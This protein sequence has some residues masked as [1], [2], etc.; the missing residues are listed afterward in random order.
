MNIGYTL[1]ATLLLIGLI[2]LTYH[3]MY[4]YVYAREVVQPLMDAEAKSLNRVSTN[5]SQ[6]EADVFDTPKAKQRN[7]KYV[8]P[9]EVKWGDDH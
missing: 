2:A 4:F 5:L 9:H 7:D 1:M 6:W 8:N 3:F